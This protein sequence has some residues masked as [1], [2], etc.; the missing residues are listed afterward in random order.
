MVGPVWFTRCGKSR[1]CRPGH[2]KP[3]HLAQ[4][5]KEVQWCIDAGLWVVPVIDSN[6]GQAACKIK[7]CVAAVT[8][9]VPIPVGTTLDR[10][11]PAAVVRWKPGYTWR[12]VEKLSSNRFLRVVARTAGQQHGCRWGIGVGVLSGIDGGHRRR[13]RRYAYWGSFLVGRPQCLR[14]HVVR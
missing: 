5:L 7:T 8:C 6:C 4:F 1:R 3:D 12:G 14:H 10:P 9:A 11:G 13:Y 2:F